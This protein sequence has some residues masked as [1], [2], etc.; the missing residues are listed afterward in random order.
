MKNHLHSVI[1]CNPNKGTVK[2]IFPLIRDHF[3]NRQYRLRD[4]KYFR[5][6]IGKRSRRRSDGATRNIKMNFGTLEG[7]N[8][9]RED[10]DSEKQ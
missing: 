9:V 8:E 3:K 4:I 10:I 5:I 1:Y 2:A 7:N 6:S